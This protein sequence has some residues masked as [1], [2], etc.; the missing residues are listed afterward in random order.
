MSSK[1]TSNVNPKQAFGN[2]KPSLTLMPLSA[3][4]ATWEALQDGAN[5]YGPFNWRERPVEIQT[6]IDAAMR[7]LRLYENGEER[8]RDT[9]VSNLGAVIACCSIIIDATAHGTS[10]DNR[11]HSS[12]TCDMLHDAEEMAAHLNQLQD[13]REREKLEGYLWEELKDI[14]EPQTTG[15]E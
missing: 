14:L 15:E 8:A 12:V 11:Q 4:I 13:E 3:Q 1:D 7:H 10:L 5:K 9:G 6:Y 2:K